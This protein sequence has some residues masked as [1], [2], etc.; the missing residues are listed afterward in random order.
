MILVLNCLM[1]HGSNYVYYSD[2]DGDLDD[3]FYSAPL[4]P[5]DVYAPASLLRRYAN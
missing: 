4:A 2:I 1:R 5:G 3:D